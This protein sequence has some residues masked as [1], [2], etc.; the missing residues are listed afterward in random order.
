MSEFE[1][2]QVPFFTPELERL[3]QK[4][5]ETAQE[6][7]REMNTRLEDCI[8]ETIESGVPASEITVARFQ[9]DPAV[10]VHVSGVPRHRIAVDLKGK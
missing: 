7:M 5:T 4:V 10:E 3:S 1:P 2:D 9:F 6:I 8:R